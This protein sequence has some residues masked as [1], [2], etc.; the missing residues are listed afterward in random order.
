MAVATKRRS[1]RTGLRKRGIDGQF[2]PK[3]SKQCRDCEEVLPVSEFNVKTRWPDG[4]ARHFQS[5]CKPCQRA[6]LRVYLGV[7]RRG[8]P[9]REKKPTMTREEY[10]ERRRERQRQRMEDPE[11]RARLAE[12]TAKR[13][14]DPEYRKRRTRQ[15]R[16]ASRNY[17]RRKATNEPWSQ[18][19]KPSERVSPVPFAHYVRTEFASVEV[20]A[21]AM[22]LDL[23]QLKGMIDP[24]RSRLS[25][26]VV[27]RALVAC[28]RTYALNVLYPVGRHRTTKWKKGNGK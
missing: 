1:V 26:V 22:K 13:M 3:G 20:A 28:G 27:D 17:K 7:Q 8:T 16:K 10:N 12:R 11:Y 14:E 6:R 24:K 25:L 18:D 19:L 23:G 5:Y 21:D 15:V 4:S 2:I 9:Y